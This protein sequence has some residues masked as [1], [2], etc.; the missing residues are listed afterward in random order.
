MVWIGHTA[1]INHSTTLEWLADPSEGSVQVNHVTITSNSVNKDIQV[2]KQVWFAFQFAESQV[3]D[4][5]F[6]RRSLWSG[7][8]LVSLKK[9][10][11]L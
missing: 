11:R 1:E 4:D 7:Q 8:N 10:P 3:F 2:R 9:K 6:E 5:C